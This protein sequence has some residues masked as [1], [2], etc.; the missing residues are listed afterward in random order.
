MPLLPLGITCFVVV[1]SVPVTGEARDVHNGHEPMASAYVQS[2]TRTQAV[3]DSKSE[4]EES[5]GG[6]T[7]CTNGQPQDSHRD[8]RS[9]AASN[10]VN[11]REGATGK[12]QGYS[13]SDGQQESNAGVPFHQRLEPNVA[14]VEELQAE[15]PRRFDL[16]WSI[17]GR[18]L[19]QPSFPVQVEAQSV[20]SGGVD[21]SASSLSLLGASFPHPKDISSGARGAWVNGHERAKVI[22]GLEKGGSVRAASSAQLPK[23]MTGEL[24]RQVA[25]LD[26][27]RISCE[28]VRE[29]LYSRQRAV[30]F[31]TN[32][33]QQLTR[34]TR[35]D[36]SNLCIAV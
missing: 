26:V 9:S 18:T 29:T 15:N 11:H 14:P 30:E 20:I 5:V 27:S 23:G 4:R 28:Q 36:I 19:L 7:Y 34:V 2:S 35:L 1:F 32:R 6:A 10:S 24:M 3:S 13:S 16:G 21:G 33:Q 25:A 31:T 12:R 8:P 22:S 17:A